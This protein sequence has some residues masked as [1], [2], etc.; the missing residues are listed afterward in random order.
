MAISNQQARDIKTRIKLFISVML[1]CTICG[2][3]TNLVLT[4]KREFP[5]RSAP[6]FNA[7]IEAKIYQT[8]GACSGAGAGAG[9]SLLPAA[10][11]SCEWIAAIDSDPVYK[12]TSARVDRA[13]VTGTA[14][15]AAAGFLFLF[16]ISLIT[17]K[18]RGAQDE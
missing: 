1:L 2:L 10:P 8:I 6:I 9:P 7:L 11:A 4:Q 3:V 18:K 14:G 15:G 17:S 16:L 13:A 5:G 12:K